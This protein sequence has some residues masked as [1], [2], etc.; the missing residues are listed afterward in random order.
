MSIPD[1]DALVSEYDTIDRIYSTI[2]VVPLSPTFPTTRYSVP[3][4][5]RMF[6][7]VLA[8]IGLSNTNGAGARLGSQP[9]FFSDRIFRK[10]VPR[11]YANFFQIRKTFQLSEQGVDRLQQSPHDSTLFA[12]GA[13]LIAS[14]ALCPSDDKGFADNPQNIQHTTGEQLRWSAYLFAFLRSNAYG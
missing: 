5:L 14:G 10:W 4:P 2:T 9:A 3:C 12:N 7:R 6:S 8:I 1:G 11:R 13:R